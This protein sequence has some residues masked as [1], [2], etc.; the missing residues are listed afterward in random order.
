MFRNY[1]YVH[2]KARINGE[3]LCAK[4]H[5]LCTPEI[6]ARNIAAVEFSSCFCII[7]RNQFLDSTIATFRAIVWRKFQCSANQISHS[8]LTP[9]SNVAL[10]TFHVNCSQVFGKPKK[11]HMHLSSFLINGE[12]KETRRFKYS[13]IREYSLY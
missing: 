13:S 12:T 4:W 1:D 3:M 8:G 5:R 9:D 10:R 2:V 11:K 7:P 6:V